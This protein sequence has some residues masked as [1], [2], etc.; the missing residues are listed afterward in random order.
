MLCQKTKNKTKPKKQ[1]NPQG[2]IKPNLAQ[3]TFYVNT[4]TK[5]SVV[6]CNSTSVQKCI[7]LVYRGCF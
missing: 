4:L 5:M 3:S 7:Q 2:D 1:N 6:L